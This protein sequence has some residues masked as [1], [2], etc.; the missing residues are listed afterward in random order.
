MGLPP[1]PFLPISAMVLVMVTDDTPVCL[2]PKSA[3]ATE[4]RLGYEEKLPKR[5]AAQ[6]VISNTMAQ[7]GV[8]LRS[9]F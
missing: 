3:G 9:L 5:Y 6:K 4:V 2:A 1:L 7:K 8:V